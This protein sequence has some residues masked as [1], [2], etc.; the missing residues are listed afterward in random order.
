MVVVYKFWFIPIGNYQMLF[1]QE[2]LE[3]SVAVNILLSLKTFWNMLVEREVQVSHCSKP[4]SLSS[5]TVSYFNTEASV[6]SLEGPREFH[7]PPLFI[8]TYGDIT[9]WGCPGLLCA[10][11]PQ[12]S[13]IFASSYAAW[14]PSADVFVQVCACV[15]FCVCQYVWHRQNTSG[16]KKLQDIYSDSIP[17]L[18][19]TFNWG[20]HIYTTIM[21]LSGLLNQ[22]C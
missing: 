14:E 8:R 5:R 16:S 10:L 9:C 17:V 4:H 19:M 6:T 15:C 22:R 7:C 21:H 13:F 18:V 2:K 3:R 11:L 12:L 20:R 1:V